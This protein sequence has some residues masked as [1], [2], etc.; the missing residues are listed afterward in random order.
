MM[1]SAGRLLVVVLLLRRFG[2]EGVDA[3]TAGSGPSPRYFMGFAATP[4]GML[5]VFGGRDLGG[6]EGKAGRGVV[7]CGGWGRLRGTPS[8]G[9]HVPHRCSLSC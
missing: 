6:N 8:C 7:G 5:Y 2:L 1:S 4:D 9:V 3:L